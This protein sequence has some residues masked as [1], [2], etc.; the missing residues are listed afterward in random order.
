VICRQPTAP[1]PPKEMVPSHTQLESRHRA[2][3]AACGCEA[4]LRSS[5]ERSKRATQRSGN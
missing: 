5:Q 1:I 4:S 3:H 2:A